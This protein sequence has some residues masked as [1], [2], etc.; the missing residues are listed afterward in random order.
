MR[1]TWYEVHVLNA[2]GRTMSTVFLTEGTPKQ[3]TD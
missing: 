3:D 2:P 1:D